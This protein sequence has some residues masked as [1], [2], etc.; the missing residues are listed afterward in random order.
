MSRAILTDLGFWTTGDGFAVGEGDATGDGFTVG[1]GA[2][3]GAG[4]GDGLGDGAGW[5]QATAIGMTS[6]SPTSSPIKTNLMLFLLFNLVTSF[7]YL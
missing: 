6:S 7:Y 4:A 1:D 5:E 3:A 2:G